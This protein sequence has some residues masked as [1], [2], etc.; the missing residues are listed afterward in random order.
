MTTTNKKKKKGFFAKQTIKRRWIVNH[1]GILFFVIL[2]IDIVLCYSIKLY[3]Y[4]NARQY[5]RTSLG[6][7]AGQLQSISD[8]K[9]INFVTE[10]NSAVEGFSDKDKME[11][12]VVDSN[13]KI[14]VTSSGFKAEESEKMPDYVL[15]ESGRTPEWQGRTSTGEEVIA[16]SRDISDISE[17]YSCIRVVSSMTIVNQN[18]Y[19]MWI[20]VSGLCLGVFL[21]LVMT[22]SY[23]VKS[24]VNPILAIN[25][26]AGK[27]ATG[28]FS[29]KIE[30][31]QNDE[32]GELGEALN[33]MANTLEN[34]EAM[35]NEFISS[36]S[37]ELRTPLTA[38][39]GW[40]EILPGE[41]DP[42]TIS[43]GM[44]IIN[45]ETDRLTKMVEELLDFSRLQ[46]GH[47]SL[48][49]KK[50]DVLAELEEAVWMYLKKA[51]AE[52]I[53]LIYKEPDN[54]PFI[55]GDGDRI[56][57]VFINIIDNAIKYSNPGGVVNVTAE[58]RGNN[59]V[60][61]VTDMGVG[62]SEKDLPKVKQKF[63]KANHTRRGSGIGLAL[64]NEI[65]EM[66]KGKLKIASK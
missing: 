4:S 28:D 66:H 11:L 22:G 16:V 54:L 47:F 57:Q 48:N 56:R 55:E 27:F 8:N 52:D 40:A 45:D 21:L 9:D 3:F 50:I 17:K 43:N 60:V 12:M 7:I 63:Y 39:K 33:R 15:L 34:A 35:K 42:K 5:L 53:K 25:R 6:S 2:I 32:I 44:R 26:I 14:S 24:I 10:L 36:V 58:E 49:I 59:I 61:T 13:G 19:S 38:I 18:I 1:L 64:A 29:E 46:T 30:I 23:F 51:E 20:M 37:H 31:K 65:V 41:T 62:I